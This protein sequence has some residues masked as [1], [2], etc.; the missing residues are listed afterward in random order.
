MIAGKPRDVAA[1]LTPEDL[2]ALDAADPLG[3]FREAFD[4][5]EGVIYL[6]GNSLG[7]PPRAAA[8]RLDATVRREWRQGLV[9]AWTD[10]GWIEAPARVGG[11]IAGLIGARPHEV[12]VA[13]STSVDLFKLIVAALTATPG[14]GTLLGVRGEFPA[15][16]Y[17]AEGAAALT[18]RR[19][20]LVE[21][22]GLEAALDQ[23]VALLVLTHAHYKTAE[24]FDMAAVTAL[25][26]A[27]GALVL[28]DLSHST[29]VAEVDLEGAGADLA[30]GCGYKYLN[31]GPGAPA[32]L[33][34]AER[35]QE[36]LASPLAGW[37]GHAAPFDFAEA[38][39]PAPGIARFLCGTPPILSLAALEAGVDLMLQAEPPAMAHKARR[40]GDVFLELAAARCPAL[41]PICPGP[42]QLRGGHVAFRHP[43]ARAL[44]P[45]LIERGVVADFRGPDILRF[46]LS[47]LYVRF[48]DVAAAVEVLAKVL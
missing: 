1:M 43:E 25:A 48:Q 42:G 33:Y 9:Q 47:P 19:L 46:G 35:H 26:H 3:R 34:V 5:P 6:A 13:D 29:G 38:Y 11:K 23:D 14:R 37:M 15:D 40:L 21:R 17:V 16:L 10:C 41:E 12:I 39:A 20:K 4:L 22:V 31:G 36:A 18:G 44:L 30:V 7:P 45:A 27:A 32:Y 8:D 24:L 28:W 2:A